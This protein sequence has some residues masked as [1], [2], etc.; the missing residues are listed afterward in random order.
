MTTADDP[1]GDLRGASLDGTSASPPPALATPRT[2]LG[3]AVMALAC[4]LYS[5]DLTVLNLALPKLSAALAPS[6]TQLL[7]IVD[8]YG[9]FVAGFLVTMGNLGDRIGRRRLLLAGA[10]FFGVASLGTAFARTASELIAARA[11]L[12]VAGA[13]VAPSTLS[14]IRNMF[15]DPRQRATA[16]GVW[17]SSFSLG[18]VIGPI[19]GGAMLQFF[20]WGSVFLLAAPVMLA[21]LVLGRAFLPEFRDPGATRMDLLS[22]VA[23][24]SAILAIVYGVKRTAELGPD[25]HAAAAVLVGLTLGAA[26]LRRQK[27][28]SEPLVDL[29]LFASPAFRALFATFVASAMVLFGAYV[30]LGQYLQLVLALTPMRAGIWLIPWSLGFLIGSL[31]VPRLGRR[32]LPL[33]LMAGGLALGTLGFAVLTQVGRG[34]LPVVVAGTVLLAFGFSPVFTLGT[35]AVMGAAPPDR[36]G[37]AA[38]LSETTFEV[39]GALGVALLGS[40]GSW[41]YRRDMDG[42][43]GTAWPAEVRRAAGDTLGEVTG[44]ATRLPSEM[45]TRLLAT[46]R[47]AFTHAMTA[48]LTICLVITLA[49]AVLAARKARQGRAAGAPT[50]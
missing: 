31:T 4:L 36:A 33:R 50:P 17:I 1:R 13:T 44:L 10:A 47:A 48:T 15:L 5:M 46:A 39:G 23:S 3:L 27:H 7:W 21:L 25:L 18:G 8:I 24:L 11:V 49:L 40:F 20:W 26:F 32:V 45:A 43:L 14:L 34:G 42:A 2:W 16:I 29:T 41:I 38:A 37:A 35:D 19:V 12:G 30:F 28:L 9:F 6:A 22:A